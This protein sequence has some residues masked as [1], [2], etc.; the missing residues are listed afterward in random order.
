MSHKLV[1]YSEQTN[2][3]RVDARNDS[4][5]IGQCTVRVAKSSDSWATFEV[6]FT[7]SSSNHWCTDNGYVFVFETEWLSALSL[8]AVGFQR[9]SHAHL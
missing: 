8:I 7:M 1:A 4:S 2:D 3:E 5:S 6:S 9:L